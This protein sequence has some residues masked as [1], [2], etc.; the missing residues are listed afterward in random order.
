MRTITPS[1]M[2]NKAGFRAIFRH[3]LKAGKV[4][5]L[6]LQTHDLN[7]ATRICNDAVFIFNDVELLKDE[8]SP[9]LLA[10]HKRSVALAFGE[11]AAEKLFAKQEHPSLVDEDEDDIGRLVE[12]IRQVVRRVPESKQEH[13]LKELLKSFESRRYKELQEQFKALENEVKVSRPRIEELELSLHQYRKKHNEHV[14]VAIGEVRKEWGID[15]AKHAAGSTVG[16]AAGAVDSFIQTL[17]EREKFRL[18]AVEAK[19][20]NAWQRGLKGVDGGDLSPVTVKKS[21]AYLSSFFTWSADHKELTSNPFD[22]AATVAGV[23]RT[24]EHILAIR[25]E[26]ELQHFI[27]DLDGYWQAWC[28]VAVLAGPRWAEQQWLKLD[29]VY[30]DDKYLRITS[31]ASGRRIVGTKTGG[32]RNIPIEKTVLLPILQ[33]HVE[34]RRAERKKR[35]AT[36]AESS[37]WLFPSFVPDNPYREREKSQPGQWSH[38]SVFLSAWNDHVEKVKGFKFKPFKS[39]AITAARE[40]ERA[41]WQADRD[42]AKSKWLGSIGNYWSYGPAEWR[43]TFG[44]MLGHCGWSSLEISRAMGN[45]PAIAERHYIATSPTAERWSFKW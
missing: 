34:A 14:K 38:G 5:C 22:T 6:S 18:G 42:A 33:A 12:R 39:D 2:P 25:R 43:H 44:T 3:P 26:S 15:Y 40:K 41:E 21:R 45:S 16:Q 35:K 31:R 7:E 28:A 27:A 8:R 11:A 30:F 13:T 32:E 1:P 17:P 29:D 36:P 20:I 37:Q 19:H 9:R 23:A 24:P 4:M 10:F